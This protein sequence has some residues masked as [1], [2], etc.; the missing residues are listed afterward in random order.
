[1]GLG[2]VAAVDEGGGAEG[3]GLDDVGA[4]LE[5]G[6]VEVEDDVG[7]GGDEVL[8]AAFEVGAAEV[9]RCEGGGLEAG[10]QPGGGFVVSAWLP[11]PERSS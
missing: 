6:A 10:A 4:G 2:E 3:V 8:V 9:F 7:A 1:M 5:V 11:A